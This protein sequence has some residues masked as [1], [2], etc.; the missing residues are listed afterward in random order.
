VESSDVFQGA[1]HPWDPPALDG[2]AAGFPPLSGPPLVPSSFAHIAIL[3]FLTGFLGP[4]LCHPSVYLSIY[5]SPVTYHLFTIYLLSFSIQLPTFHLVA[6]YLSAYLAI[7]YLS[8]SYLLATNLAVIH[9][10]II[11]HLSF[12]LSTYH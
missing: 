4:L 1:P 10:S 9:L 12:L 6:I 2:A 11:F 8:L 5:L 7:I 3:L